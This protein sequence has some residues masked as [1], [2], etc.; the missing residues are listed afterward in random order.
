[1]VEQVPQRTCVRDGDRVECQG[2]LLP[3]AIFTTRRLASR[4]RS[5]ASASTLRTRSRRIER[6]HRS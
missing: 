5:R 1:M 3:G 6:R 4:W 2:G